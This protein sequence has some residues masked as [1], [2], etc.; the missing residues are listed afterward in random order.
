MNKRVITLGEIM[1]RLSTPGHE[2]FVSSNQYN[3]VYGGAEA[4]VAISL[5]NWG[6]STAHVTAF[7]NND[8]GKAALQYLRYAGLDTQYVYFEEGRMGLYF[9][10]NG[11]MQRS[12]KII[13]DRFDSVF[14]NFD[15]DKIDWKAVFKGADW[16]HWT[17]I[18]PAI[19]ASAAKICTE[20]VNAASELG[21]KIS[22]DINYRR[23]LW[24]YGKQPLDIMPD[25]I[26]KTNVVIAGL[27]D[28]ENCMDIHEQ[29]YEAACKKAQ[30]KCP[31]I[32]YISTTHRNSISASHNGLSGVLW[33][34][35]EL[36]ESKSYDMTHIVD[37][38][39]G[40]DAYMAGLIYGLLE[41]EDQAALEYAV[42]ASVLK[43]SIPGDANFVT[44]DE[45]S[46]LVKGENVGKLLR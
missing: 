46:Q 6:I 33:N 19:S 37:R 43:H 22:G 3:I 32:E 34:G 25:L 42:A 27:T 8:I 31:S 9:V 15:G 24:Q 26:A 40:G 5:A 36:L 18:T 2:R 4:N 20:A 7:P 12:S 35:H 23:N 13:Y 30:E 28:F 21:V 1:M 14:A 17:G 10:E 16:F 38:V 39:G 29:D 44:V 41:G 45:V 11:A